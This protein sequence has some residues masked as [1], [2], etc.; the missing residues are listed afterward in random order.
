[1]KGHNTNSCG[2]KYFVPIHFCYRDIVRCIHQKL[3]IEARHFAILRRLAKAQRFA[4]VTSLEC[5]SPHCECLVVWN[6][7]CGLCS[8]VIS[9]RF[10]YI[11]W[12]FNSDNI[13]VY[14]VLVIV[15]LFC[16]C[17]TSMPYAE[18]VQKITNDCL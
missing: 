17:G 8:K 15:S 1:M 18:G 12:L 3:Q 5:F 16:H 7:C 2:V 13:S 11:L 6:Y 14:A 10:L 9:W 4:V